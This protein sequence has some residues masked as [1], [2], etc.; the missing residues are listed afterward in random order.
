MKTKHLKAAGAAVSLLI[1]SGPALAVSTG[2]E[3]LGVSPVALDAF[4]F[5]CPLGTASARASVSDNLTFFNLPARMRVILTK[6]AVVPPFAPQAEDV[7]PALAGG[8]GGNP[9]VTVA[10]FGGPGPYR[11]M[12]LKTAVGFESYV[13]SITCHNF[14]GFAI[15]PATIP[16]LPA[17]PQQNQ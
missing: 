1:A 8:E 12:F 6:L 4:T 5:S 13:G 3:T 2:P 14:F 10:V 7:T 9:S 15:S 11:A 16:V 17:V